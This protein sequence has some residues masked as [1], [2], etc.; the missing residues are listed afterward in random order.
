MTATQTRLEDRM[1]LEPD[2][3]G[4]LTVLE[5]VQPMVGF[6]DHRRFALTRLDESGLVCDLRAVDDEL[7][8][9]V[10][11]P[12]AFF[13][14]YAPEIDDSVV[15][16]LGIESAD[17]VV[18]L[19]VVTL[20]ETPESATANLMAPVLVNHRTRR[21]GQFLLDDADLPLRAPLAPVGAG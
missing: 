8:F 1:E 9:V 17:D 13:A 4:D 3:A 14:E 21:A 18:V 10:V 11:P 20:G 12:V 15:D 7:R 6:P 5:M 16:Q 19:L 2:D